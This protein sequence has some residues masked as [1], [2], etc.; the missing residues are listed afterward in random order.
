MQAYG[1]WVPISIVFASFP[2]VFIAI[3]LLPETLTINLKSQRAEADDPALRTFKQHMT[4][5]LNELA[6]SLKMLENTSVLLV[7]V[8]FF[9]QNA[10]FTAYTTT[11]GQYVSKSFGWKLAE[12]SLLLS[13]LG[14]LNLVVLGVLPKISQILVSPR[15]RMS[16]FGKD[17]FLTKIST[18]ILVVGA[19]VQ[20]FAHNVVLFLFGLFISTFG[21]ADSPL[22]R[23][24]VTHYVAPEYTS[25]LYA[26]IGM[27][28]VI[29]SFIG[30]P[31]L[32]W[33]FD[34]GM[35]NKGPWMGLPWFYVSFLCCLAWTALL[36][37]KP[38]R[39]N[40]PEER[41]D[42]IIDE[43]EDFLPD[44]PLRLS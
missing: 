39:K 32:A 12:T 43:A 15:F 30:G 38:P 22:A 1:P 8:T 24:T 26:L 7:L 28:E 10:R 29:G 23:A 40:S 31:V 11:L 16:P 35:R 19:I 3:M 42:S 14:I 6:Y 21:A 4:H 20:G 13:P 18:C 5:G 2:V 36:F 27:I 44:D 33:C 9:V 34:M 17:L 41:R 37:V 25:R